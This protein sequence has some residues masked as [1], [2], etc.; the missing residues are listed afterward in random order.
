VADEK[1]N[2]NPLA[3][4]VG[5]IVLVGLAWFY[6]GGGLE[7]ET[8]RTMAKI[9]DK[10]AADAVEQYNITVRS[11]S[12]MDRCVHAGIVAAAYLQAKNEA[13]YKRWK[14]TEDADCKAAGVPR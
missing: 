4:V 5:L 13:Y 10:V 9:H 11:G 1:T 3:G 6:F 7:Q 2:S 8:D 14:D 12:A